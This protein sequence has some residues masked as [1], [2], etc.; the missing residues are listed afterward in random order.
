MKWEDNFPYKSIA[1]IEEFSLKYW[2]EAMAAE[3][4]GVYV[5][6]TKSSRKFS[7]ER[8]CI[9]AGEDKSINFVSTKGI[10][11]MKV[12]IMGK[13]PCVTALPSYK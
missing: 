8:V 3:L 7:R 12:F 10:S 1:D 5:W 6:I 11:T 9:L 13:D 4:G 2:L